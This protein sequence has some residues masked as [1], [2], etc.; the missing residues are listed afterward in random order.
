M[1]PFLLI[2]LIMMATSSS[3]FHNPSLFGGLDSSFV[4]S[5][6]MRKSTMVGLEKGMCVHDD[7]IKLFF[8]L[9]LMHEKEVL[10]YHWR[11]KRW[12]YLV[13]EDV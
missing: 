2:L 10:R 1:N 12:Q 9:L 4:S 6:N 11:N 5:S 3:C 13:Q 8:L 7:D